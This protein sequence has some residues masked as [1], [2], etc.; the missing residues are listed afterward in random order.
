[1]DFLVCL[2]ISVL[3]ASAQGKPEELPI[4]CEA[5]ATRKGDNIEVVCNFNTAITDIQSAHIAVD[6]YDKGSNNPDEVV[7]CTNLHSS[8]FQCESKR[9]GYTFK[10][11]TNSDKMVLEILNVKKEDEGL[12]VCKLMAPGIDRTR[13]TPCQL[14]VIEST[15]PDTHSTASDISDTNELVV[16]NSDSSD[17]GKKATPAASEESVDQSVIIGSSASGVLLL[18]VTIFLICFVVRRRRRNGAT[19]KDTEKGGVTDCD[20]TGSSSS[21]LNQSDTI[22]DTQEEESDPLIN[23]EGKANHHME[24]NESEQKSFAKDGEYLSNRSE[25][26]GLAMPKHPAETSEASDKREVT[27]SAR[28]AH[29]EG[30][31]TDGDITHVTPSEVPSTTCYTST[32]GYAHS[33]PQPLVTSN[34]N[35]SYENEGEDEDDAEKED[36]DK[37]T[38]TERKDQ[39]LERLKRGGAVATAAFANLDG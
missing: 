15:N 23:V 7:S 27:D 12:F 36:T 9:P 1:M 28:F 2:L 38:P 22:I 10:T 3:F 24:E 18:A 33:D 20:S 19:S 32:P 39:V 31:Q 21:S 26:E 5:P 4:T 11:T 30:R 34:P 29:A 37:M 8:A 16:D 13:P 6:K 17:V 25:E 35:G 14:V